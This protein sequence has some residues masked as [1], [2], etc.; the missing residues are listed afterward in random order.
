MQLIRGRG[1]A[2]LSRLHGV[3]RALRRLI[4]RVLGFCEGGNRRIPRRISI[5]IAL[6]ALLDHPI[7][8]GVGGL[9]CDFPAR[10]IQIRDLDLAFEPAARGEGLELDV[11][12]RVILHLDRA[13][14]VE[15]F[16]AG[17]VCVICRIED[18]T[19]DGDMTAVDFDIADDEAVIG[20]VIG[21]AFDFLPRLVRDEDL[22]AGRHLRHVRHIDF[23][24]AIH[25]EELV[26][27]RDGDRMIRDAA[28]DF[29]VDIHIARGNEDIAIRQDAAS[30][31]RIRLAVLVDILQTARV[32]QRIA[33]DAGNARVRP[34]TARIIGLDEIPVRRGH[35]HA[36][37]VNRTLIVHVAIRTRDGDRAARVIDVALEIDIR[38]G[39]V[40]RLIVIHIRLR[41]E[42]VLDGDRGAACLV[43][44]LGIK[45]NGFR[46]VLVLLLDRRADR[47]R[48]V[49]LDLGAVEI[50]RAA[51]TGACRALAADDVDIPHHQV[52]RRIIRDLHFR[53][54]AR[55]ERACAGDIVPFEDDIPELRGDVAHKEIMRHLRVGLAVE[56]VVLLAV[57]RDLAAFDFIAVRIEE[58]PTLLGAFLVIEEILRQL[59][60]GIELVV[61]VDAD[62]LRC[63]LLLFLLRQG[64]LLRRDA[65]L[66]ILRRVGGNRIA[67]AR[68]V[69]S[70]R[71]G[72]CLFFARLF[73]ISGICILYRLIVCDDFSFRGIGFYIHIQSLIR[74]LRQLF[75]C[76]SSRCER[77]LRVGS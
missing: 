43:A 57:L 28:L 12:I 54:A 77:T 52:V 72:I 74:C 21:N 40:G 49:A 5:R 7:L 75:H 53:I 47:L 16:D 37:R 76:R 3:V 32:V 48:A 10:L 23:R 50:N 44:R 62:I 64:V 25:V 29:R 4:F 61:I 33:A 65:C 68:V 59:N 22:R 24:A 63:L 11:L 13:V 34:R 41:A 67:V 35:I 26:L 17:F 71:T 51:L 73:C 60:L 36:A 42:I 6:D 20:F 30:E 39:V 1:A 56:E 70:D 31:R 46:L 27:L 55:L 9:S 19:D 38:C 15:G 58:L 8:S 69:A 45:G 18:G 2:V 14:A 66:V